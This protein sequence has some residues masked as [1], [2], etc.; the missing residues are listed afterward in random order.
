MYTYRNTHTHKH[1][2]ICVCSTKLLTRQHLRSFY[3]QAAQRAVNP[4]ESGLEPGIGVA[5]E[6]LRRGL[7]RASFFIRGCLL[8]FDG[9]IFLKRFHVDLS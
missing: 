8:Q 4:S 1:M 5:A 6:V 2:S 9:G 7:Q 3:C